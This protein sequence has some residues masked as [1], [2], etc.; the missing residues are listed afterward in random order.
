[1]DGNERFKLQSF[2]IR[3][4]SATPLIASCMT[5]ICMIIQKLEYY[6]P[7]KSLILPKLGVDEFLISFDFHLLFDFFI[8]EIDI[9]VI[10]SMNSTSYFDST[11]N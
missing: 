10:H 8:Y 2:N 1:M 3:N 5:Y 6:L 4:R 9:G 7:L 11:T